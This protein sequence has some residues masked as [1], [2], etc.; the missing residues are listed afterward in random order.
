MKP[1][2]ILIVDD[3][4]VVRNGIRS[5]METLRDFEVVGEAATGEEAI[6]LVSE[7]IPDVVLMDLIMPGMDGI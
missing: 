2:S 5:Y 7:H 6:R 3:H 4:E 1:I